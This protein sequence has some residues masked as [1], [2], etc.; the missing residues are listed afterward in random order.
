VKTFDAARHAQLAMLLGEDIQGNWTLEISDEAR[1]DE[2]R[3]RRWSLEADVLSEGTQRFESAPGRTIPDNDPAGIED[4]INVTGIGSLHNIAVE[5]DITHTWIG[6]LQ[7]SLR[8]PSETE[9]ILHAQE[10]R[11]ADDI[12][13]TYTVSDEP[14]LGNLIGQIADG[15]WVLKVSDRAGLDVGKLNRWALKLS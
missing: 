1:Y 8:S 3:L 5:V 4:R 15:D 12:Q 6:D 2:G 10:G 11:S 13:H 7:V 9:V 14:A